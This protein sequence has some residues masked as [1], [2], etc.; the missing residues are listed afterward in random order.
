MFIHYA[1][2]KAILARLTSRVESQVVVPRPGEVVNR[3]ALQPLVG[4]A[5]TGKTCLVRYWAEEYWTTEKERKQFPNIV[6]A[7]LGEVEKSSLGRRGVYVT[8]ITC[9]AFS[10]MT[11][12]LSRVA[13]RFHRNWFTKTWYHQSKKVYTDNQFY[14]LFCFVAEEIIRLQITAVIIDSAHLLDKIAL[15]KLLELWELTNRQFWIVLVFT[16]EPNAKPSE[17]IYYWSRLV[18]RAQHEFEPTLIL[19][20]MSHEEGQGTVLVKLLG[21]L[22]LRFDPQLSKDEIRRM[23]TIWWEATG[24]DWTTID[25]KI[26]RIA[27]ELHEQGGEHRYLTRAIFE[28]AT[29]REL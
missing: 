25:N 5:G 7:P 10:M 6:Y 3:L 2:T 18:P 23:R 15:E 24:G 20:R 28:A 4:H 27:I 14:S 29:G 11:F 19:E 17:P 16:L 8:P 1:N 26:R 12:G 21:Q 13:A 22:G 9:A